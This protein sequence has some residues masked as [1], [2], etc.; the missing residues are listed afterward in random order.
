[1]K[2]NNKIKVINKKVDIKKSIE[3]I[4][5][6]TFYINKWRKYF[7][8]TPYKI[9]ILATVLA[10][11]IVLSAFSAFALTPLVIGGFLRV[12]ISFLTYII[13]W[14]LVN[15]FYSLLLVI[16][17]T[18]L[19]YVGVDPNAEPIGLLTMNLSDLFAL[20]FFIL[21]SNLLNMKKEHTGKMKIYIKYIF[22]AV[23]V[24]ISTGFFNILINFTFILDMYS[25]YMGVEA[26]KALKTYSFA[27]VLIFF[28]FI[29]YVTNFWLFLTFYETINIIYKK[30]IFS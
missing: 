7:K 22:A 5:T 12:E 18:W 19:R 1:M 26:I 30:S 17:A 25:E 23:V 11:N 14:K 28:N 4:E 10:L 20:S 16:P 13:A 8:L 2:D 9:A 6:G 15:G 3:E 21:V 29:K 24:S 27:S